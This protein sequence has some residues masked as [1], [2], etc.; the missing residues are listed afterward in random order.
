[1]PVTQVH[2]TIER[3]ETKLVCDRCRRAVAIGE[4]Y[5]PLPNCTLCNVCV[6]DMSAAALAER[7]GCQR[8]RMTEEDAKLFEEE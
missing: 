3:R 1:M 2:A 5:W 7:M 8:Y 6:S 4:T